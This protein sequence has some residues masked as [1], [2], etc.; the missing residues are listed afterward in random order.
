MFIQRM[1]FYLREARGY[2]IHKLDTNYIPSKI[3]RDYFNECLS[4]VLIS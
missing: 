2:Y 1:C 4:P 3:M